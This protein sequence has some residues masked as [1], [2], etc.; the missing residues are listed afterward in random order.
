MTYNKKSGKI[1]NM[2]EMQT[3]N[4]NHS[5]KEK[6]DLKGNT[7]AFF[8]KNQALFFAPILVLCMYV[9]A[10]IC[11]GVWPFGDAYTLAS[12]DLSAQIA[13]FIEHIFDVLQGKSSWTYSYAIAGGADITGTFLY[14]FISPFSFLFLLFGEGMVAHASSIVLGCKLM[15]IAFAGAWFAKKLF[16]GIPDYLCV[17]VGVLY[18]YCGYA[19]VSCTYINWMDFLIYLPFATGAFIRFVKTGKFVCFSLWI[20][21]CI[22]TCF[23]IACFAMFTVFPVLVIY[24]LLCLDRK[25]CKKYVA[26][27]CLAFFVAIVIALPVLLPAL[28]AYLQSGRGGD[29]L[30]TNVWFGFIQNIESGEIALDKQAFLDKWSVS[31]YKKW[32]YILS[33][34]AFFA[35]TLVW[36]FRRSLRD[37]FSVFMLVAGIITLI[38]TFVDESMLLLNM[39]SYMEY[40]LRF[41]FL[42]ALYLLGGACLALENIC[43]QK[44]RAYDGGLLIDKNAQKI[45]NDIPMYAT[46]EQKAG[47]NGYRL[48]MPSIVFLALSGFIIAFLVWF[49]SGSNYKNIWNFTTDNPDILSNFQSVSSRFAHSLGGVE[50]VA[51]FFVLVGILT[52]VGVTFVA[53]KKVSARFLSILLLVVVSVQAVFYNNQ[54]VVGNRSQ[55]HIDLQSY[56]TLSQTLNER[57]DGYFRVKDYSDKFTANAP[58]TADS[59]SFSVFSSVIDSKNF[60]VLELFG[61]DGNGKNTLKSAHNRNKSNRCSVFGDSFLGYKYYLVPESDCDEIETDL[62]MKK[63]VKPVMVQGENGEQLQLSHGDFY[64]FENEIVFPSAYRVSSGEFRFTYPNTANATYRKYNQQALYQFLRGKTLEEMQ[65]VTGS[66]TASLVTVETARELSE[67]LWDKSAQVEVGAGTITATTQAQAGEYLF[68]HFVASNGYQ[69]TVNGKKAELVT[70]DLHMLCVQLEEGENTVVFTYRS[71]FVAYMGMGILASVALLCA[72]EFVLKRTKIWQAITPIIAW[73][74]CAVTVGVIAFYFVFPTVTWLTK[75]VYLMI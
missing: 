27:L 57:E 53:K 74:G 56:Q 41:G 20:A 69:V 5:T 36:F 52:A 7:R 8:T 47:K 38:P 12:Y 43:Y 25:P 21:A 32:S 67:Y 48:S 42:N 39:G 31:L 22:Y 72:I 45:Q 68:L 15:A 6:R 46:N 66:A 14:F 51:V 50:V 64:V 73:A 63:Y 1:R 19:F 17:A 75:L 4:V 18:A 9:V 34:S 24:G 62:Q 49:I 35:L 70:N 54:I 65:S 58:F 40:A 2:E 11:Y 26:E 71:P 10:L 29:G 16:L 33:D 61:Y 55:Q 23:S 13:P 28:S 37:R 60:T 59:N 30:L 3:L 44:N